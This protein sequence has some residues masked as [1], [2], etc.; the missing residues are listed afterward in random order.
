M[1]AC[2]CVLRVGAA[3]LCPL[4]QSADRRQ[5]GATDSPSTGQFPLPLPSYRDL[6]LHLAS[7]TPHILLYYSSP[8]QIPA[9]RRHTDKNLNIVFSVRK[10]GALTGTRR[11]SNLGRVQRVMER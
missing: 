1:C 10:V 7:A 5:H 4:R 8:S 2:M 3:G 11:I 9:E 6:H